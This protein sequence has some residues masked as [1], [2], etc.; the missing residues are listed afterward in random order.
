[1]RLRL[2][3]RLV[4]RITVPLLDDITVTAALMR[5]FA[6]GEGGGQPTTRR[7]ST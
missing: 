6:I 1:M 7:L 3:Y 4:E 2:G 5:K